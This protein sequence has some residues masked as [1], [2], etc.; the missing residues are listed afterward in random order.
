[1]IDFEFQYPLLALSGVAESP[2][3]AGVDGCVPSHHDGTQ[4]GGDAMTECRD[5]RGF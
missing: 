2:H 5:D 3:A 1:M 4:S